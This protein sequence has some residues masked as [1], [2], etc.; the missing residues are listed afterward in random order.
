MH[1]LVQ[2]AVDIEV[3]APLGKNAQ[4]DFL[5]RNA[6]R[7]GR[8]AYVKVTVDDGACVPHPGAEARFARQ[9]GVFY[10]Q[11]KVVDEDLRQTARQVFEPLEGSRAEIRKPRSTAIQGIW[12][13]TAF[14]GT[15]RVVLVCPCDDP[16]ERASFRARTA[17]VQQDKEARW[18]DLPV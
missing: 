12:M 10:L 3:L 11:R 13:K 17:I 4:R 5:E 18:R 1:D 9:P 8:A 16:L 6:V 14:I 7:P 2:I 15:D